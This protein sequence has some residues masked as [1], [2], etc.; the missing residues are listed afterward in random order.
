VTG[1]YHWRGSCQ[2]PVRVLFIYR[3]LK[4][5]WE[6]CLDYLPCEREESSGFQHHKDAAGLS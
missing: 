1:L 6:L 3:P 5:I 2:P 4:S